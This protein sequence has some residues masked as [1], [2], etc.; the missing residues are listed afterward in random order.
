MFSVGDYQITGALGG[1]PVSHVTK[2]NVALVGHRL[3]TFQLTTWAAHEEVAR[4]S[5]SIRVRRRFT[6]QLLG[7]RQQILRN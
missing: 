7:L 5:D 2:K 1:E 4:T 6:R 3:P